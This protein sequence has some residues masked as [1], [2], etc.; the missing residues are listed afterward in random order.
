MVP[1][2][3]E[4]EVFGKI[5][6]LSREK[7]DPKK[8][9]INFPCIELEHLTQETGRIIGYADST[10]LEST[11]N[12]FKAGNVLFGKLRPY[13]KKYAKPD[14]DGVCSSEI[15]VFLPT[16]KL[17]ADYLFQLV[18]TDTF[19]AEANKSAGS[20]MP[21]ADWNIISEFLF[22]LPPLPEQRRI[23]QILS[24]WD[25]TIITVEKLLANDKQQKKILM[26]QV[27]TGKR[28]F[29]EFHK[30]W[31]KVNLS[32][33][34]FINPKK[35]LP[36][37]N[38]K[39]TFLPM[40]AVSEEAKI[41]KFECRDYSAVSKG[42]TSFIDKDVLVAKITPC[43]ENG[44]GGYAENLTNGIGFGS[45][46][47]HV[48]RAKDGFCSKFIYYITNTVEFRV[49]GEMNMQGSAGQKRVT[50]DY[51]NFYS[52]T[53]PPTLKEQ[54]KISSLL[55]ILDRKI[56][57]LRQKLTCLKQEKKALMQQLLTG[58]RRVKVAE[59]NNA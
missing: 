31:K 23:A 13:L 51:L 58:K 10:K 41:T 16:K 56:E 33:I 40:E 18:Q 48:I 15:W 9:S 35:P 7:Y 29:F 43:F 21:R 3:W 49:K 52:L 44:K 54:Q 6:N 42:F 28:R 12:K 30:K 11:K 59:I 20:K 5:V 26:Q 4:N 32:E 45:T 36:P 24:T 47:F 14:F 27:L 25:K 17:N 2:G 46:E 53:I 57:I 38:G 1:D 37:L 19:I 39:V 8:S 22:P 50:T 55:S 34:S